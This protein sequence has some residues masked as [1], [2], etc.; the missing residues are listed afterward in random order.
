MYFCVVCCDF[1]IFI[2][3]FIDL[4]FLPFILGEGESEVAQSRP[5]LV[6][7][8]TVVYQGSPSMGFSRQ[9]YWTGLPFPSPMHASEK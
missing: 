4:I 2:S 7:P 9:E 6:T 3:T 5:T 1:S 8:W